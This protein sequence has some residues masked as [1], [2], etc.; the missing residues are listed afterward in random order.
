MYNYVWSTWCLT[1]PSTPPAVAR[2]RELSV[3]LARCNALGAQGRKLSGSHWKSVE[4]PTV[5]VCTWVVSSWRK[6]NEIGWKLNIK[7]QAT[8]N[9]VGFSGKIENPA[10]LWVPNDF[11]TWIRDPPE[12]EY[13]PENTRLFFTIKFLSIEPCP[14]EKPACGLVPKSG[15]LQTPLLHQFYHRSSTSPKSPFQFF[16]FQFSKLTIFNQNPIQFI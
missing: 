11:G 6:G 2:Q 10:G 16:N 7:N 4:F 3:L 8:K 9:G 12:L 14:L 15:Y 13:H 5:S 1:W